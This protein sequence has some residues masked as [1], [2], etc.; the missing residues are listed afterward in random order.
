VTRFA[1]D[2]WG[3]GGGAAAGQGNANWQ[4]LADLN[5]SNQ[6]QTRYLRGDAVDQ[7]FARMSSG[8]TAAWYLTDDLGSVRQLT[9]GSGVVQDTIAYDAYGSI[10]SESSSTFGDRYKYTGREWDVETNLQYNRARYYDPKVGR[11]TSQDP[12]GFDAGDSNLYR[13]VANQPTVFLDPSGEAGGSHTYVR[14]SPAQLQALSADV[15]KGIYP[16]EQTMRQIVMS[17]FTGKDPHPDDEE[18]L[19]ELKKTLGP[20]HEMFKASK[21][22]DRILLTVIKK[23]LLIPAPTSADL[24]PRV[25]DYLNGLLAKISSAS[26]R[27][28]EK[29]SHDF[30]STCKDSMLWEQRVELSLLK[31]ALK[32]QDLTLE[33]VRRIETLV[34]TVEALI[35]VEKRKPSSDIRHLYMIFVVDIYREVDPTR[36]RAVPFVQLMRATGK[37]ADPLIRESYENNIQAIM[38]DLEPR[39]P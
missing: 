2:G 14:F 39:D 9:D 20:I 26:F 3:T 22:M 10:T 15:K 27:V 31:A 25:R 13:Y 21:Q 35:D 8:G 17:Y 12:L 28:R 18:G 16:N 1:Q 33:E 32:N 6:L 4:V 19:A 38:S 36:R 11:W 23:D 30:L 5:N 29:A 7:L 37:I 34:S 24:E